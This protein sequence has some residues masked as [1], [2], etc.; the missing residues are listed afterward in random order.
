MGKLKE[1]LLNNLSEEQMEDIFGISAFEYV[2][3]MAKYKDDENYIPTDAE[4]EDIEKMVEDY[5]KSKEFAEYVET[6]NLDEVFAEHNA[7]E[8]GIDFD[9]INASLA[10]TFTEDEIIEAIR[11]CKNEDWF[12]NRIS[13]ELNSIWNRKNGF[14]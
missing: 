2:E 1:K 8:E 9:E 4:V 10:R 14:E 7:H 11:S 3:L 13:R 6:L 12:I 5:Y